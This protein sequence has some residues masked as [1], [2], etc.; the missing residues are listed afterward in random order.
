MYYNY[1]LLSSSCAIA[2]SVCRHLECVS[3][4]YDFICKVPTIDLFSAKQNWCPS[5]FIFTKAHPLDS[6][7]GPALYGYIME[8]FMNNMH[9]TFHF[10]LSL[11]WFGL[12]FFPSIWWKGPNIPCFLW[13]FVKIKLVKLFYHIK[14]IIVR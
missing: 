11:P 10:V 4:Q 14:Y 6:I 5:L 2:S 9:R 3:L 13:N 8:M 12:Y 1:I 7:D